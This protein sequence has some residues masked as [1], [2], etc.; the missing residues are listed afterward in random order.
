MSKHK[1]DNPAAGQEPPRAELLRR[2]FENV[3]PALLGLGEKDWSELLKKVAVA[4]SPAGPA[5]AWLRDGRTRLSKAISPSMHR[6][7][8]L[9]AATDI[10]WP[11]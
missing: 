2:L 10:C 8:T 1:P 4:T 5:S 6:Y 7:W 3:D 9:V 11:G